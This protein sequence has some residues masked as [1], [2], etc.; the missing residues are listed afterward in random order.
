MVTPKRIVG[1]AALTAYWVVTGGTVFHAANQDRPVSWFAAQ[2]GAGFGPVWAVRRHLVQKPPR[3]NEKQSVPPTGHCA[4]S[5]ADCRRVAT[6]IIV[7]P[8][9]LMLCFTLR[10]HPWSSMPTAR[11]RVFAFSRASRRWHNSTDFLSKHPGGGDAIMGVRRFSTDVNARAFAN[12][13]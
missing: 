12:V 5:V 7:P 3:S 4:R 6:L 13:C 1:Y 8:V 10:N 9:T 11:C 2:Y